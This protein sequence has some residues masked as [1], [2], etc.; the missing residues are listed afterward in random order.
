LN[1]EGERNHTA[2]FII[3]LY[4]LQN[5]LDHRLSTQNLRKTQIRF[6]LFETLFYVL[7][8]TGIFIFS[9]YWGYF[10]I[11]AYN[12]Q[13]YNYCLP[14]IVIWYLIIVLWAFIEGSH[15]LIAATVFYIIIYY[16]KLR[17]KQIGRLIK[18][19]RNNNN[20]NLNLLMKLIS[21]HNKLTIETKKCNILM[22]LC[23]FF[24]YYFGTVVVNLILIS[25]IYVKSDTYL[26]LALI[27]LTLICFI[28][29]FFVTYSI[30]QLSKEA[31]GSYN[32]IYSILVKRKFQLM[33][34]MEVN[35]F[36]FKI[37]SQSIK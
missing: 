8:N 34:R 21:S 22:S 27:G 12:S 31:H 13:E 25:T 17:F 23:L 24:M 19:I 30:G 14:I 29:L 5:D 9:I 32:F 10:Y 3:H 6:K 7:R 2:Y 1:F 16:L 37:S 18:Q 26:R 35:F 4:A 11:S 20:N 36:F 33:I 15:C 28:S